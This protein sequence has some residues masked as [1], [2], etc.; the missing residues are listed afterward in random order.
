M[1][2]GQSGKRRAFSLPELLVAV[3][4]IAVLIGLLLIAVQKARA[5]ADRVSAVNNLYQLGLAL[6]HYHVVTKRFP[7]ECGD[8]PSVYT[9]LLPYVEEKNATTATPVKSFL[10]PG[11]RSTD[12]GAKRD[13]GYAASNAVDSNGK[14]ILD[15][16]G[17]VSIGDISI[18]SSNVYLLTSLWM[19]P[20]DYKGGDPTDLSWAQKLNGRMI[21][22]SIKADN[23]PSGSSKNLGGPFASVQP[24]LYADGRVESV[25]YKSYTNRW[26]FNNPAPS[27]SPETPAET[28]VAQTPGSTPSTPM[29]YNSQDPGY[30]RY[31]VNGKAVPDFYGVRPGDTVQVVIYGNPYTQDK[32][33]SGGG[34]TSTSQWGGNEPVKYDAGTQIGPNLSNNQTGQVTQSQVSSM[35]QNPWDGTPSST[36]LPGGG[37]SQTGN[38]SNNQVYSLVAYSTTRND[39]Q[40]FDW[41]CQKF[42]STDSVVVSN[43]SITTLT[44]KIPPS[45]YPSGGAF[46][47]D[48]VKGPPLYAPGYTA[49]NRWLDSTVWTPKGVG[50]E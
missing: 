28:P 21:G 42:Y 50:V 47:L 30:C 11:R 8:N 9:A 36:T 20:R 5:T 10:C 40:I 34:Y 44:V 29:S 39:N 19:D 35:N 1:K 38:N 46:Q 7:T 25:P 15:S 18:G 43:S 6:H 24:I 41:T 45:A 13:F 37:S 22:N 4:V 16:E 32:N 2:R 33:Y 31:F 3:A 48:F 26:A 12:A 49:L 17:G 14:S 23:D 27:A